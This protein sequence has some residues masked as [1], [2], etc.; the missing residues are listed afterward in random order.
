VTAH[1]ESGVK[2]GGKFV[3]VQ[4]DVSKRTEIATFLDRVPEELKKVD[5]L[6]ASSFALHIGLSGY[7]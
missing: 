3:P 1:Q 2:A 6:G 4:L 5:I 7:Y